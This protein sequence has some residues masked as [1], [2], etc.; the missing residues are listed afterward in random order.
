MM[1]MVMIM[2]MMRQGRQ[3]KRRKDDIR[4]WTGLVFA[5]S[6]R[7]MENKGEKMEETG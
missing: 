1:M 2:I 4:E 7:A 3:K 6:Q 5:K